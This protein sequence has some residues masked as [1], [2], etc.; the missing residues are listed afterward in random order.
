MANRFGKS[1]GFVVTAVN[2]QGEES[3]PSAVATA[4]F[5]RPRAASLAD[6]I[7]TLEKLAQGF[8]LTHDY[9]GAGEIW[10]YHLAAEAVTAQKLAAQ[11]VYLNHLA[12][13]PLTAA[14]GKSST[15]II[16]TINAS[17]ETGTLT[18]A[19]KRIHLASDSVIADGVIQ[20]AAI[21]AGAVTADKINVTDLSAISADMGTLTAGQ[22]NVGSGL[23]KIGADV[24]GTDDGIYVGQG[25]TIIVTDADGNVVFDANSK[26]QGVL[27][28]MM[29]FPNTQVYNAA[30]PITFTDLDLSSVVGA[31]RAWVLLRVHN[32]GALGTGY[33]FRE[34]GD[35][36]VTAEDA[37]IPRG[38][39]AA[40]LAGP[41]A[42]YFLVPTD[43]A[44]IVEWR[45]G[46]AN[47][48]T[49]TVKSF[50]RA[51]S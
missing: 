38:T 18:I 35:T 16:A 7:I 3:A 45:A 42:G 11:T 51:A 15:E 39:G 23:V 10:T 27:Q 37:T 29:G 30:A 31:Y 1:Y 49:I 50:I 32:T 36:D 44:G 48:T 40:Y 22:I 9:I 20:A 21:A 24:Y 26:F 8:E 47:V 43:N 12:F 41:Q 28:V 46:A 33:W 14:A 13:T 6:H 34:N 4:S 25:G 5:Q 19:S 17:P 2:R